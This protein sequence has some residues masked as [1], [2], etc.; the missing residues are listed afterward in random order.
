MLICGI[1][2]EATSVDPK[3]AR[4]IE[5]GAALWDTGLQMPVKLFSV[6]VDPLVEIPEE[7]TAITGITG[8]LVE[9][10]G[11]SECSALIGLDGLIQNSDYCMAHNGTQYDFPLWQN[12]CERNRRGS[13]SPLWIDSRTDI[14]FDPQV[15]TRNLKYLAAER[16][17]INPF[18]HRAVFDVLTMLRVASDFDWDAIVARAKEP[19]VFVQALVSFEEKE[20][21]KARGYMWCAPKKI[22]WKNFKSSDFEADKF[23]CPF[24]TQL[25]NGAPE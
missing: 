8:D 13:A 9:S 15:T 7:V 12:A 16:G 6:L 22:W 5:I 2:F 1:D 21:A 4:I 10:W 14:K 24:R 25:L 20:L 3:E 23:E 18:P 19:T 17:F 11:D